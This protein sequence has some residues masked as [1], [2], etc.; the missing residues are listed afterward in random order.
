MSVYAFLSA[1]VLGQRWNQV[2]NDTSVLCVVVDSGTEGEIWGLCSGDG[3]KMACL[4][5][6]QWWGMPVMTVRHDC[7]C[8]TSQRK[9]R[10]S[11][12][13][14]NATWTW[15]PIFQTVPVGMGGRSVPFIP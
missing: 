11:A 9:K 1:C 2:R 5:H 7:K 6:G 10:S 8:D 3:C 4:C 13:V 15:L 14:V 12:I